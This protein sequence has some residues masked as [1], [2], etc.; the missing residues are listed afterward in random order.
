[1]FEG[2]T[3]LEALFEEEIRVFL[4]ELFEDFGER[5]TDFR[6]E[7]DVIFVYVAQRLYVF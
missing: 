1:M 2:K 4:V 5:P 3:V 6:S 7:C